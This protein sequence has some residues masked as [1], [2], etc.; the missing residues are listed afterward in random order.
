VTAPGSRRGPLLLRP[1]GF[2]HLDREIAHAVHEPNLG[3]ALEVT[4]DSLGHA[5]FEEL[6]EPRHGLRRSSPFPFH[7]LGLHGLHHPK[8]G[9]WTLD[10]RIEGAPS[11]GTH[12]L[13][14]GVAPPA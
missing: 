9:W 7:A 2:G 1:G 6:D 8:R 12:Q 13:R 4:I 11:C 3:H 14:G 10:R 5:A